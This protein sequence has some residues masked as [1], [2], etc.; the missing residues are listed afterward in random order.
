MRITDFYIGQKASVSKSFTSE[1]VRQ[2][3]SLSLDS[4]PI[5]LDEEYAT[6]SMFGRELVHGFLVGSLISSVFGTKLPGQGSIYLHQDMDFRKPVYH[7]EEITATVEIV[8]IKEE[9]SILYFN[10]ICTKA[11]GTVV[12]EGSA[13]IKVV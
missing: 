5:H 6:K 2:F 1:D 12:V 3:A 7:N 13:V 4:N 10:T 11:D 8:G 9:K